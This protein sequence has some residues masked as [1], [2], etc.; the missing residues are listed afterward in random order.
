MFWVGYLL[1][2]TLPR[3]SVSKPEH[4]FCFAFIQSQNLN[5]L[6]ASTDKF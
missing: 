1:R 5:N 6:P 2:V 4:A 3:E